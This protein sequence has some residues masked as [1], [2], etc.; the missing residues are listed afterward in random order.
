VVL[1][2]ALGLLAIFCL[3][4]C[5]KQSGDAIV[6][7]KELIAAA[8]PISETSPASSPAS[9]NEILTTSEEPRPIG[10]DE[11]T[12]DGYV[13][14]LELRGTS[15]DPRALK[16]EQW[17]VKVR[18]NYD[19][20]TFNI[21]AEQRQF[22]K[23]KEGDR[24]Q[25]SYRLGKYTKTV[26]GAEIEETRKWESL[27]IESERSLTGL[28]MIA[29]WH[30]QMRWQPAAPL[31]TSTFV[32]TMFAPQ[33]IPSAFTGSVPT[34]LQFPTEAFRPVRSLRHMTTQ[35]LQEAAQVI[36]NQQ[37]LINV[38]SKR[39]RQLGLGHRPMVE[40]TPRMSLTDIALKEIIAGKLTFEALES[41]DGA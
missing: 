41:S 4:G 15:R 14:K 29:R 1:R 20:R 21:Q 7:T 3:A 27:E 34:I 13:M 2:F 22:N 38:V 40:T 19:G 12:L 10:D 11:I 39:V 24:V 8:P 5:E 26:W 36:P 9:P 28:G 35:L 33:L 16:D 31:G 32:F 30:E 25:V 17:R 23:L 37:L 18:M 6:L